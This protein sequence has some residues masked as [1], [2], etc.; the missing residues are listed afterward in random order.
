[1]GGNTLPCTGEAE[2][3][4]GGGLN[5]DAVKR[6]TAG[7]GDILT[8]FQN[9]RRKLRRLRKNGGVDVADRKTMLF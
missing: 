1:M 9:M 6:H 5:A 3:F 7:G 8:H 4:L 2:P